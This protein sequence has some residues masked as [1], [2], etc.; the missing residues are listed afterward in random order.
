MGMSFPAAEG[1]PTTPR[2]LTADEANVLWWLQAEREWHRE[3][4]YLRV[5]AELDKAAQ[6]EQDR[7]DAERREEWRL[8]QIAHAALVRGTSGLRRAVLEQHAPHDGYRFPTCS[9]C[10]G[11]A[12]EEV[13]FPCPTYTLARDWSGEK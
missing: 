2:M 4:D 10:D 6:E 13:R 7:L 11:G 3:Q 5:R 12:Y 1:Q 9:D 8:I